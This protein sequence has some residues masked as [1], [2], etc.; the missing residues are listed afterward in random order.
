[1]TETELLRALLIDALNEGKIS[2]NDVRRILNKW[3]EH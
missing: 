1:M 2:P 3:E